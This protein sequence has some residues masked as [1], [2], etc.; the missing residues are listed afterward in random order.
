MRILGV[1]W[2]NL[3]S[4]EVE[5]E[6]RLDEAP[7]GQVGLFAITGPTGAGKT[8]ILDAMC[9]ALFDRTPRLSRGRAP[10]VGRTAV[11]EGIAALDPRNLLRRGAGSGHA[12]CSFEGR[13]GKEYRATWRARRARNNPGGR[14]QAVDMELVEVASGKQ[15]GGTKTEVQAAI[16][17]RLGLDFDQFRRSVLLAQ[18]DFAAFLRAGE[19]E[20]ADL[21]ERVTGTEIYAALGRAAWDRASDAQA[22]L[23]ALRLEQQALGLLDAETRAGLE[24]RGAEARW[25]LDQMEHA[26]TQANRSWDAHGERAALRKQ[27][28]TAESAVEVAEAGWVE[29]AGDRGRLAALEGLQ[30]HLPVVTALD[31]AT[32]RAALARRLAEERTLAAAAAAAEVT[33][34]NM[35]VDEAAAAVARRNE[36]GTALAPQLA[37]ADRLDAAL[38]AGREQVRVA[39]ARAR[40]A[41]EAARR[42]D[43][44]VE[45]LA[46]EVAVLQTQAASAT[47][48]LEEHAADGVLAR[49]LDA[50]THQIDV[51]ID[52]AEQLQAVDQARPPLVAAAEDAE[53]AKTRASTALDAA[54]AAFGAARTE[55]EAARRA[56]DATD[57]QALA[58]QLERVRAR[59][60]AL[61]RVRAAA[62]ERDQAEA[63]EAEIA[64]TLAQEA[65]ELE[66]ARLAMAASLEAQPGAVGRHEGAEQALRGARAALDL[67]ARRAELVDG[68]PCPLCGAEEHPW[69]EHA[70]AFARM[71]TTLEGQVEAAWRALVALREEHARQEERVRQFE[72]RG[73]ALGAQRDRVRGMA[74]AAADAIGAAWAAAGL[75]RVDHTDL[76]SALDAAL[77]AAQTQRDTLEDQLRTARA[78]ELAARGAEAAERGALEALDRS[79]EQERASSAALLAARAALTENTA[80]QTTQRERDAAAREALESLLGPLSASSP[81]ELR[82]E[83]MRRASAWRE[84]EAARARAVE[85]LEAARAQLATAS[86]TQAVAAAASAQTVSELAARR[87]EHQTATVARAGILDGRPTAEVRAEL[88]TRA[89]AADGALSTA[90]ARAAG[91]QAALAAARALA[92]AA[93]QQVAD[94]DAERGTAAKALGQL[95]ADLSVDEPALRAQLA[96]VEQLP[97]LQAAVAG[98]RTALERARAVHAERL[99][100]LAAAEARPTPALTLA[101]CSEVLWVVGAFAIEPDAGRTALDAGAESAIRRQHAQVAALEQEIHRDEQARA[102]NADLTPRLARAQADAA[103]WQTMRDLIGD[104]TGAKF[105]RFAQSLTLEMLLREANTHLAELNPR[106]I[107]ERVPDDDGRVLLEMQVV[108]REMGDEVRPVSSLSG[109]EGFLVSLALALALSSLSSDGGSI[110]SLF[111]DEGFG[112]LDADTL[113][114]AIAALEALQHG[115]RQVGVISHVRGFAEKIGA[116]VRVVPEGA[117][118]SRVEVSGPGYA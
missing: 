3:A 65:I 110:G 81:T 67:E 93:A 5:K 24:A 103:L 102:Q 87:D 66:Q 74:R 41:A 98:L 10:V 92:G 90:Q 28:G 52:A 11:D 56:R 14:L 64:A 23:D 40:E 85:G 45:R 8:T 94:A 60:Q 108:D 53:A 47:A 13:D 2:Q 4:L 30:A 88:Q 33:A 72:E 12:S 48:W 57:A 17:E 50:V 39:E 76:A 78:L 106:Y 101:E 91:A 55:A 113:E 68:D 112:T 49:S 16:V 9:L 111:I 105:K 59:L 69:A 43:A 18:G 71:I 32:A 95:C 118:L 62:Q 21:L 89:A 114:V 20:R 83:L 115:G 109:G 80:R 75:E 116:Q 79:R 22:S 46:G 73:L 42:S 35:A 36:E 19:K 61:E 7:L 70:P 86:S 51:R 96:A 58:E 1:G 6:V 37:A 31:G 25:R 104:A 97:A 29:A 84:Q 44:I 77:G 100:D 54:T 27:V 117:G 26:R 38:T 99:K 63:A 34:A 15:L 82:G 107:L